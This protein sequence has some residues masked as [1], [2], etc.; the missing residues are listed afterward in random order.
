MPPKSVAAKRK[1]SVPKRRN[2]LALKEIKFY[3]STTHLLISKMPFVRAVKGVLQD[4]YPNNELRWTKDALSC[5]QEAAEAYIISVMSDANLC[6]RHGKRVTLMPK[7]LHLIVR[8]RG[9]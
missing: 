5:L 7:D 4:I 6:A 9:T 8:I 1:K 2:T 3:M